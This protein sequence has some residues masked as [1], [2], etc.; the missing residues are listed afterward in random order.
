M[1][2]LVQAGLGVT[3]MPAALA[4]VAW[5][6]LRKLPLR[7]HHPAIETTIAWRMGE[8]SPVLQRLLR[9]ALSTPEPDVLGPDHA[10]PLPDPQFVP[11][12]RYACGLPSTCHCGQ[13]SSL[14][15]RPAAATDAAHRHPPH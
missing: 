13:A 3:M 11:A 14:S 10:R 8:T 12:A 5:S 15:P 7:Q 4:D 9:I 6:G 2:A 1:L